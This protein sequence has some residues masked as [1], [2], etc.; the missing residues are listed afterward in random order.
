MTRRT[1]GSASSSRAGSR[2]GSCGPSATTTASWPARW[3]IGP[4]PAARRSTVSGP[5]PPSCRSS[6]SA[7]SP[8]L[9]HD[10]EGTL[11][12]AVEEVIRWASPVNYMARTATRDVELHGQLIWAGDKVALLYS[13][14]NRDEAVFEGPDRFDVRRSP[15]HHLGF[16]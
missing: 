14:A 11:D 13:S 10:P 12:T 8:A 9:R 15:N 6:P 5:W 1:S 4:W 2:L 3:W 7:R 16:G